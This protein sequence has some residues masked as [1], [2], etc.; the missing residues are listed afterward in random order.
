MRKTYQYFFFIHERA[1]VL[2][3][4]FWI[5]HGFR[6][7]NNTASPYTIGDPA[8]SSLDAPG[9]LPSIRARRVHENRGPT[10]SRKISNRFNVL[11]CGGKD[12]QHGELF[13]TI[14]RQVGGTQNTEGKIVA[15][16]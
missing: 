5:G 14:C 15:S 4:R 10:S 12:D 6:Q 8:L 13:E 2:G 11:H 3:K 9:R 7:L 16:Q 1:N